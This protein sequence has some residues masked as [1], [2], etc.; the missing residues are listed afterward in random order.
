MSKVYVLMVRH[1]DPQWGEN[2]S[3]LG[4]YLKRAKAMGELYLRREDP[5]DQSLVV[6]QWEV[7]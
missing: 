5:E 1:P 7:E 6:E 4:V 3:I 2:K